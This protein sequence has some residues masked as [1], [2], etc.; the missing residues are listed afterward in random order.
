V[1]DRPCGQP[2]EDCACFY[3]RDNSEGALP[4]CRYQVLA[5]DDAS[6]AVVLDRETMR[7]ARIPEHALMPAYA[8][9]ADDECWRILIAQWDPP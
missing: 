5:W 2:P 4:P 3:F 7:S 6:F 8:R 1:N 9:G